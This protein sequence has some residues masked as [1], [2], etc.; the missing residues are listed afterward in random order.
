MSLHLA[1]R[2]IQGLAGGTIA[3]KNPDGSSIAGYVSPNLQG[4]DI[5]HKASVDRVP[6]QSGDTGCIIIT[7]EYIEVAFDFF[8][9]GST[10]TF[11]LASA[12]I[13]QAGAS[14][15]ISGLPIIK[16]GPFADGLNTNGATT[17]PWIYEADGGLNGKAKEK[18]DGKITMRRYV[19]ITNATAIA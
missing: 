13:P 14:A 19:A 11:A 9:Q 1:A 5:S 6:N 3:F 16:L 18:W 17:N 2:N 8:P 15:Q 10:L 4:L 7:D 12:Q